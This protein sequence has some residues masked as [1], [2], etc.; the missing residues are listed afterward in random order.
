M[1][2]SERKN[3]EPT[4]IVLRFHIFMRLKKKKNIKKTPTTQK[5]SPIGKVI[6][7]YQ[8]YLNEIYCKACQINI[9]KGQRSFTDNMNPNFPTKIG[10]TK[11]KG[12]SVPSVTEFLA[13]ILIVLSSGVTVVIPQ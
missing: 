13:L 9:F 6:A 11:G 2:P 1:K 8:F 5:T 3:P 12:R 10:A 4:K 7:F